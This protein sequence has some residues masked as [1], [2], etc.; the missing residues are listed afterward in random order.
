MQEERL[1][2]LLTNY[3]RNTISR[4]ELKE[5]L[6]KLD[7]LDESQFSFLFERMEEEIPVRSELFDRDSVARQLSH[8]IQ[9]NKEESADSGRN[10]INYVK[11]GV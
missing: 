6:D 11:W 2:Y 1:R 10:R 5:M 3:F 4:T 9:E 7:D 8:R